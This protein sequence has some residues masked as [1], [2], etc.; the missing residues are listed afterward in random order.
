M[1]ALPLAAGG[2][3]DGRHALGEPG[4]AVQQRAHLKERVEIDV[5]CRAAEPGEARN[6]GLEQ[7]GGIRV[8]EELP[9]LWARHA[10]SKAC[11]LRA[12]TR[13]AGRRRARIPV[14][15][16]AAADH[17]QHRRRIRHGQ[18]EHRH[19]IERAAGRHDTARAD[20]AT[21]RLQPDDVIERRRDPSGPGGVGAQ[22]KGDKAGRDRDGRT[23]ARSAGNEGRIERVRRHPVRRARAD[24]AGRELIE[25]GLADQQRAGGKQPLD[26]RRGSLRRVREARAGGGG[27]QTG[28]VDIVLDRERQAVER[29]RRE[30]LGRGAAFECCRCRQ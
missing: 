30:A 20:H 25:I 16:I 10:G 15:R 26:G 13:K 17:L 5:Y 28:D 27:R 29:H 7:R 9:L 2:L 14:L 4:A 18:R 24:E 12:E 21:G 19:A 1:Q 6:R 23:R 11:R 8:A 3:V 22:R